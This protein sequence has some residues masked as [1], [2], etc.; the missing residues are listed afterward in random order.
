MNVQRILMLFATSVNIAKS[1]ETP[2]FLDLSAYAPTAEYMRNAKNKLQLSTYSAGQS[3]QES[4]IQA[5]T[6]YF[7]VS[8]YADSQ[9]STSPYAAAG[10]LLGTCIPFS[11]ADNIGSFIPSCSSDPTCTTF[12]V[13]IYF[14]SDCTSFSITDCA[15]ATWPNTDVPITSSCYQQTDTMYTTTS[16]VTS[17]N[18]WEDTFDGLLTV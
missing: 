1:I 6:Q 14:T 12:Q 4:G 8:S 17:D 7:V 13:T 11:G 9:C 5:A 2:P 16:C 18:P 10:V 3:L 15:P